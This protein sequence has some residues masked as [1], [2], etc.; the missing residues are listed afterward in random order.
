MEVEN[1]RDVFLGVVLLAALGVYRPRWLQRYLLIC[2]ALGILKEFFPLT[3]A[4]LSRGRQYLIRTARLR[5]RR[6]QKKRVVYWKQQPQ[7]PFLSLPGEIRNAIYEEVAESITRVK[8]WHGTAIL[9]PLALTCHQARREFLPYFEAAIFP[10]IAKNGVN[11]VT[12]CDAMQ[13]QMFAWQNHEAGTYSADIEAMWHNWQD[14]AEDMRDEWRELREMRSLSDAK[15]S[16]ALP[17][18]VEDLLDGSRFRVEYELGRRGKQ[19]VVGD[20]VVV[21]MTSMRFPKDGLVPDFVFTLE[22][23]EEEAFRLDTGPTRELSRSVMD[24]LRSSRSTTKDQFRRTKR[25]KLS[26][27][28]YEYE[29]T[30]QRCGHRRRLSEGNS[31]DPEHLFRVHV[32]RK[33][34]T[35]ALQ[36]LGLEWIAEDP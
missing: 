34:S 8:I 18:H 33:R 32:L 25:R 21:C 30:G 28:D 2:I 5:N 35:A 26:S 24:R 36:R 9:H 16:R 22:R 7:S 15:T 20:R 11:S 17:T 31:S 10:S 12:V 6:K 14:K 13:V 19:G 27:L 4:Q 23:E 1:T 29:Q 3:F